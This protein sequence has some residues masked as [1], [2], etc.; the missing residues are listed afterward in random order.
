M[1]RK[2]I[3]PR[4]SFER[5]QFPGFI[6]AGSSI[7]KLGAFEEERE[8]RSRISRGTSEI[9]HTTLVLSDGDPDLADD[10]RASL[11]AS[12]TSEARRAWIVEINVPVLQSG[13][14]RLC[15]SGGDRCRAIGLAV[16]SWD[17]G[18]DPTA[19]RLRSER[20]KGAGR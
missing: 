6:R 19:G 4:I 14:G 13:G 15:D 16:R 17:I 2:H 5:G 12:M 8:I 11:P 9:V 1:R 10:S 18:R 3:S 20:K 7:G